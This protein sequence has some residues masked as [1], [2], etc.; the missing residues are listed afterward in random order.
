MSVTEKTEHVTTSLYDKYRPRTWGEIV[1]QPIAVK[2]LKNSLAK[3]TARQFLLSGPSG[4]G[5]TTAARVA[6]KDVQCYG[7]NFMEIA[8]AKFTGIDAMR[9]VQDAV[10]YSPLG[11][12]RSRCVLVD[13]CHGLS[14]QA[15]DSLLKA[16]EEPAKHVYWF[17]T[18]TD[19]SKVPKTIHTRCTKINFKSVSDEDLRELVCDVCD[20][21]KYK[22]SDSII[23]LVIREAYGSPR[24]AL[25]NL[26]SVCDLTDKKEA[27]EALHT[28]LDTEPIIELCRFVTKGT[29]SWS[30]AM[31]IVKKLENENPESVRLV[32]VNYIAK[33]LQG[34]KNNDSATALLATL[35]A[36]DGYYHPSEKLGPLLRSIGRVLFRG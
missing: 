36:F 9:E 12:S 30:M 20:S 7:Q 21:E 11:K 3:G 15:W 13:E 1:G 22:T 25:V 4:C 26:A 14:K 35:D 18:T 8:A 2:I 24:Q 23:D 17:F 27:A 28:V 33:A 31:S 29:G 32:A 19:P 16:I 5:K 34:A 6:A 10:L